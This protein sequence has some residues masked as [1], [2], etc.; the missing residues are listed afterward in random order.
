MQTYIDANILQQH[1]LNNMF[2]HG[3][4]NIIPFHKLY[5]EGLEDYLFKI[6]LTQFIPFPYW[7][8]EI[9]PIPSEFWVVD[10]DCSTFS[11]ATCTSPTSNTPNAGWN[12]QVSATGPLWTNEWNISHNSMNN[13]TTFQSY[14]N[15]WKFT[16]GEGHVAV[17][18]NMVDMNYSPSSLVFWFWHAYLDNIA[19]VKNCAMSSLSM[20]FWESPGLSM[21]DALNINYVFDIGNEPSQHNYTNPED[22]YNSPDIWVRNQADGIG[23]QI[24][25][26]P[27]ENAVNYIYVRIRNRSCFTQSGHKLK[28]GWAKATASLDYPIDFDNSSPD[29]YLNGSEFTVQTIPPMGPGE[30]YIMEIAWTPVN[31]FQYINNFGANFNKFTIL[32]ILDDYA[33]PNNFTVTNEIEAINSVAGLNIQTTQQQPLTLTTSAPN[34]M[35]TCSGSVSLA[36]NNNVNITNFLWSD[37]ISGTGTPQ[38]RNDFFPGPGYLTIWINGISISYNYDINPSTTTNWHST[39]DNINGYEDKIIKILTDNSTHDVY[40][41]GEFQIESQIY[42]SNLSFATG[43][44]KTGIFVVKY[45]ECGNELWAVHTHKSNPGWVDRMEAIDMVFVG[46]N[47]RVFGKT[48]GNGPS[49][50]QFITSS[51]GST[52]NIDITNGQAFSSDISFSGN[53]SNP[54]TYNFQYSD[55]IHQTIID[56]NA[57]YFAG[58]FSGYAGVKKWANG[59]MT[60]VMEDLNLENEIRA[61]VLS[62]SDIYAVANLQTDANFVGAVTVPVLGQTEAVLLKSDGVTVID[63]QPAYANNFVQATDI[64]K[65]AY[66]NFWVSAQFD[67]E[68]PGW[69]TSNSHIRTGIVVNFNSDLDPLESFFINPSLVHDLQE[70]SANSISIENDQLY[71]AGTF[72]GTEIVIGNSNYGFTTPSTIFGSRYS[73]D[74]W[75]AKY[76]FNDQMFTWIEG[77]NS[78]EE[79]E[80]NDITF[81][82]MNAYMGGA[83]K[84]NIDFMNKLVNLNHPQSSSDFLGFAI[85][86]GDLMSGGAQGLY[87]KTNG[88]TTTNE[89]KEEAMDQTTRLSIYPNPNEG[90]FTLSYIS[91]TL[92]NLEVI[93]FD[94]TGSIVYQVISNKNSEVMEQE[95]N[96]SH[97]ST[98][99]YMIKSQQHEVTKYQKIMIK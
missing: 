35:G 46:S 33:I 17:G 67:E 54:Q 5:L 79:V 3:D 59:S 7:N 87:Y 60:L 43:N 97:L 34:C 37:G 94:L 80:L 20:P 48:D 89:N 53:I 50:F 14:I 19:A 44:M 98:G 26:A 4:N 77:S 11:N 9:G 66:G 47:I 23:N 58:Q 99:I 84:Q 92:G 51:N 70:S 73:A 27:I 69:R 32:A 15:H 76:D 49:L 72:I 42:N 83:Y 74:L 86:G 85:R 55:I 30:S 57:T 93:I 61:M 40:V 38:N 36:I 6:G 95:I 75:M 78:S 91:E 45:D 24:H 12:T 82:G 65:D 56:G 16:H 22:W 88:N 10:A 62:G 18:G 25:Q 64:A 1:A 41:L 63:I 29:G 8:P 2:I 21:N 31:S 96:L 68:L 13:T 52:G 28:L 81:D 71:V 39:T 90:T